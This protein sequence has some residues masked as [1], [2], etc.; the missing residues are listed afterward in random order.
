MRS[1]SLGTM[2]NDPLGAK[3]GAMPN[4]R[5]IDARQGLIRV[6]PVGAAAI[7]ATRC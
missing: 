2:P 1:A 3:I 6:L 7:G 4:L 5:A